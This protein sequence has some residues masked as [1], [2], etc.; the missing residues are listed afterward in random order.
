MQFWKERENNIL[1]YML[2][3]VQLSHYPDPSVN[4][5]RMCKNQ[6]HP[7]TSLLPEPEVPYQAQA[8]GLNIVTA[9]NR[10]NIKIIE[11]KLLLNVTSTSWPFDLRHYFFP[12][13]Y[14]FYEKE[15]LQFIDEDI[16]SLM[17][18][19]VGLLCL[20][21]DVYSLCLYKLK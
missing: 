12:P 16:L 11:M 15:S 18:C 5:C 8:G 20:R 1:K 3:L 21:P 14:F 7:P 9:D 13:I 4:I 17:I 10:K 6:T 2:F 19:P